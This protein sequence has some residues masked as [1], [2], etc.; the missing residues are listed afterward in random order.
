MWGRGHILAL[1]AAC[2]L[3][4][5]AAAARAAD[6]SEDADGILNPQEL[7]IEYFARKADDRVFDPRLCLYGYPAAKMGDH[8]SARR[9]FERCAKEGVL[10][11]MPW[12]A[13]TEEN[14]YDRPSDPAKAAEWDRKAADAGYSI[15]QFNYGLDLLRGH[16]VRRDEVLGRS[17]I[18]RAARQGDADAADLA[19]HGYDPEFS[20]PEADKDR[21]RQRLY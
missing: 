15:G 8:V 21:Y 12:M 10:A 5:A 18:D 11:A 9:I 2:W 14:G 7:T 16:G 1:C 13:W 3:S 17:F 19:A 6:T 4:A 20:T